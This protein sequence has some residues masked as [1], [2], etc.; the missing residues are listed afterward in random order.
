MSRLH[1]DPQD[2]L[3]SALGVTFIHA[4]IG[5]ALLTGLGYTT[6]PRP[7]D[8]PRLIDVSLDQPAPPAKPPLPEP[9]TRDTRKPKD[10]EGAAA[11][12]NKKYAP[13]QVVAP[14]P[15]IV[16]PPPVSIPVAPIAGQ[17]NAPAAGAAQLPGPGT[18]AGGIGVGLGSGLSGT[19]TGGGGG[20]GLAARAR[21]LSGRIDPDDYPPAAMARRAQGIVYLRFTVTQRGRVRNCAVT[22][23]SGHRDLDDTTCRLLERRL[24]YRPARDR[25]G[26]AV[27]ETIR[28]QQSW[29]MGPEP[30]VREYEGILVEE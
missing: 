20:G 19:G 27:A 11:P 4:L 7:V 8:V 10:P 13:T 21:W 24:R 9:T 23:S 30:P 1:A 15:V 3:K 2:R 17:G 6:V 12:P 25:S 18:G 22:R 14:R 29:E 28:G 5:Y 26:R 16:L